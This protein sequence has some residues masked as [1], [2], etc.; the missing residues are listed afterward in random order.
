MDLRGLGA[1]LSAIGGYFS[2]Q[3][4]AKA[5][6]LQG[7]LMGEELTERRKR[8][9]MAE[10]AHQEQL[11]VS[12][13]QRRR[14]QQQMEQE[15]ELFPIKKEGLIT[16]VETA[17]LNLEDTRLWSLYRQGVVPSQITDPVLRARYEPFFNF[18]TTA[19]TL[20][21][22]QTR[23]ELQAILEK[24]PEEWRSSLEI[25]G[26]ANL[27][28]NQMRKEMIE[29][30]L[31]TA[32]INLAQGEFALRTTKLNTALSVIVSNIEREGM[33]WD[34][35][36]PQQKI[37]AVKKWL[38]QT[39]LSDVVSEDFA[40]MFQRVKSTDARQFALYRLQAELQ[41]RLSADL[42]RQQFAYNQSLQQQAWWGNIV[43]GALTGGMGAGVGGGVGTGVAP[44]G[45]G[46]PM[47]P[48]SVFANAPDTRGSIL[49]ETELKK[50]LQVPMDIAVP[51][52]VGNQ[53]VYEPLSI[54]QAKAGA[55]YHK[56]GRSSPDLTLDDITTLVRFDAGLYQAGA[57]AGGMNLGWD[58]VLQMGADRVLYMLKA[59]SAY[60]TNPQF[61][62][63]V[64]DWERAF[65]Q[66]Q[67]QRQAQQG[68][69]Q[70]GQAQQGRPPQQG[71][72]ARRGGGMQ[73]PPM[74]QGD[75]PR[76]QIGRQP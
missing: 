30:Q 5:G 37:E 31:R 42:A 29:R 4:G 11:E 35:R 68:Q 9:K 20:E 23:E 16:Q 59:L 18:Q 24:V 12:R 64:D 36:T 63:V 65:R 6:Q 62:K 49:N 51:N 61:R 44:V 58:V 47:A 71:Q 43:A 7:L 41:H 54:L 70:Q 27:F 76:G 10:E 57:L 55:I 45:F 38:A 13:L 67:H 52:R 53:V 3:A 15:E 19:R 48:I 33:D 25:L 69:A 56:L 2:A 39:G 40:N 34:K 50:Y 1:F 73:T 21:G 26:Q 60:R 66:R 14:A 32:D 22:V 75:I 72:P 8:M 74:T 28:T 17:K 46:V